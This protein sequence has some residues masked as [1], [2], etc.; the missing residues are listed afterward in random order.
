MKVLIISHMY[1]STFNNMSGIFVHQQAKALVNQGCEVKVVSPVPLAPFPINKLSAKW[2]A[3][4]NIPFK[5]VM[6]SIEIYYPRYIEFPKGILFYKSGE[7]MALGI[8]NIVEE[9]YKEFKF[10]IIH[11]NVALPDGY[12]AMKVNEKY[13]VPHIVTVHGQDFQNTMTRNEKCRKALFKTLNKVDKIVTVS[14]KLKNAVKDESFYEKIEVVNNGIDK[15]CLDYKIQNKDKIE[16]NIKILSVS[17]L[18]KTKGIHI[19]LK[20]ISNLIE[21][22]PN[23]QY[24]IIGDGE[25]KE[26]LKVLVED[27]GLEKN[28][29]FLGKLPHDEVIKQMALCEIFSLPSYKEGFGMVYIEGMAQGKPV[30]GVKGEGIEDAID[31]GINGFLVERENVHELIKVLDYLIGNEEARIDIGNNGK[32]TV[33]ENFTWDINAKKVISIYKSLLK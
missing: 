33:K 22:Y 19:N 10:D 14:N 4:S 11:S 17:N 21:K 30:I 2:K 12:S 23:I 31:N 24:D 29:N 18:K 16:N 8:Q 32:I 6:D 15:I 7:F 13:N 20:A 26:E 5:T 1:P 3:Y 27:F 9:I 28:V 25:F